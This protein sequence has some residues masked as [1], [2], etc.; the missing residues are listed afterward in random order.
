MRKLLSF[1]IFLFFV[2][3][4][5]AAPPVLEEIP[6]PQNLTE[7]SAYQYD[8]NA[9]GGEGDL[10][11][12]DDSPYFTID[13]ATGLISFTPINEMI[14]DFIAVIIVRDENF[15]VDAQAVNFSVNGLA[16][17]TDLDDGNVT[18]DGQFYYDINA[19]D[20]EDGTNVNYVD[21]SSM[22]VI[23]STTGI[24]NFTTSDADINAHT[25]TI[26]INDSLNA[27]NS[28]TFTLN[29][30]DWPNITAIPNSTSTEDLNFELNISDYTNNTVG[31]LNFTDDSDFF[32]INSTTG[33]INF[34][35]NGSM[36]GENYL[37]T[38]TAED[39]YGLSGAGTF[40][41]NVTDTNDPPIFSTIDTQTGKIGVQFVLDINATDEEGNEISY[42]DNATFFDINL[43]TGL[44]NFSVNTSMTGIHIINISINDTLGGNYS[45]TFVL[46]LTNNTESTFG[47]NFSATINPEI[48]AY[49]DSNFGDTNYGGSAY[50]W[51]SDASGAIKRSYL[52]FSLAE[53]ASHSL[54][55]YSS[56]N[57]TLETNLSGTNLTLF[58]VNQAWDTG[59][60][61]YNDQPT[62]N[63]AESS[64][65]SSVG[66]QGDDSFDVTDLTRGWFNGTLN[67]SGVSIRFED[68]AGN[69]G[70]IKYYSKD[71]SNN[72][73]W[74]FLYVIYNK[75]IANK[76][77]IAGNNETNYL[78]LDDYFYD[79]DSLD[80]LTYEV[81]DPSNC[82]ITIDSDN[83]MSIFTTLETTASSEIIR[84]NAT[85]GF[86][87]SYSNWFSI[88]IVAASQETTTVVS[89][90]S[91]GGGGGSKNA[92][93]AI[94]LDSSRDSITKGEV[95][96]LALE[97][98]NIGQVRIDSI[99]LGLSSD[100]E[101]LDMT[102]SLEEIDSLETDEKV[103]LTMVLDSRHAGEGS[104]IITL[105]A[106]SD[107][108]TVN[109]SSIFVL[110]IEGEGDAIQKE[111]VFA[112][113]LFRNNPECL[114]LK[115][116]IDNAQDSLDAGNYNE[117]K[118]N[119]AIAIESCRQLVKTQQLSKVPVDKLSFG[120]IMVML[121][122][123]TV[124]IL[125][126]YIVYRKVKY[127]D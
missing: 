44:I 92:A 72:T 9:T 50:L 39:N 126:G 121:T 124:L 101:G 61:T 86:N 1:S 82:N 45:D 114:E 107:D 67:N 42:Y 8:V 37:I 116:L 15:S 14:G 90:G 29:I 23:N 26:T 32:V 40:Y 19:T 36:V 58:L 31:T 17:F 84:V 24:I 41:F 87:Y 76:T 54:I 105:S 111:I 10:V 73:K 78:D 62:I 113:D 75:T 30:N 77:I 7:A 65:F 21:D 94:S 99:D 27:Q 103:D 112:Q 98:E 85:D 102:L 110:D 43:T 5:Y 81:G 25:I 20:P 60:I 11:Y 49:V 104:Y 88:E 18:V 80:T 106:V 63:S 96:Q 118:S 127:K 22:F 74:P 122:L 123:L 52:N 47:K 51:L 64:N 38:I 6:G 53:I 115:E 28:S 71:S 79:P 16:Y 2:G 34:T 91:G 12:S 120:N 119:I 56:L 68:E 46:N 70:N 33:L 97:I 35:P 69:T 4:V 66:N 93:L 89:S 13:S 83:N 109:D 48:D 95:L 55:L 57:L 108:P 125:G 59:N 100:R 117:A 3:M